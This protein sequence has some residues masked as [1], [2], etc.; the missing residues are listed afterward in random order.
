M[1]KYSRVL[2]TGK[3]QITCPYGNGHVGVDVVKYKG[4]TDYIIAHSDGE[5][6]SVVKNYNKTDT[7]GN[8]YGNYVKIK[9]SDGYYTLYA[10][11]KYGTVTVNVGSKVK[12]G[13]TIGYMGN[14]GY[15]KGAHLHF[16]VWKGNKRINPTPYLDKDLPSTKVIYYRT[17]HGG[18]WQGTKMNGQQSGNGIRWISAY[19]IK[20]NV[21]TVYY[22]SHL[23]E[24]KKWLPEVKKWDD[25]ANG[26]AG[27][28][29]K[30]SDGLM[31]EL[32][33]PSGVIIPIRYRVKTKKYGWHPWVTGYNTKDAV[34]G[35]AGAFGSEITA[36]EIEIK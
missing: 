24:E 21:G 33:S 18:K 11:M 28:F 23:M 5:V 3:N 35:Y 8:S 20:S 14:T 6:V 32:V 1:S 25:T 29:G 27:I 34:N 22:R 4:Q 15:S 31:V 30:K 36:V 19:Q 2:K 17:H 7:K 10:H 9:H 16:E 13:Q 12:K 26:F